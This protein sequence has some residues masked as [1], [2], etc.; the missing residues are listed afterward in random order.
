MHLKPY[1]LIFK[2]NLAKDMSY[3]FNFLLAYI[4]RITQLLL[5]LVVWSLIFKD[6]SQINGYNWNEITTYFALMTIGT[7]VFYPSHMLNATSYSERNIKLF[8]Y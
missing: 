3:R 8:S 4:L 6:Q 2:A 5:Y 1:F 7:M